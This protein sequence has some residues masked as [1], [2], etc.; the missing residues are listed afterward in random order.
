L[1]LDEN[2]EADTALYNPDLFEGDR[3]LSENQT[4]LNAIVSD[5]QRWPGNVIPFVIDR[6]LCK[7]IYMIE[8]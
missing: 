8:N 3:I 1:C 4:D 2:L 7:I 5:A 6:S